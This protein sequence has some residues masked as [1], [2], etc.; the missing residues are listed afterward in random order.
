[1]GCVSGK[2]QGVRYVSLPVIRGI[3]DAVYAERASED[4]LSARNLWNSRA[5]ERHVFDSRIALPLEGAGGGMSSGLRYSLS[6]VS[7]GNV[8]RTCQGYEQDP[9]A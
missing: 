3:A 7:D 6:S 4:S 5:A 1:M 2:G 9:A 8:R